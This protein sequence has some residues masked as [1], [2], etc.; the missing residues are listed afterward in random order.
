MSEECQIWE[1][2]SKNQEDEQ[3]NRTLV[4]RKI[5]RVESNHVHNLKLLIIAA[6]AAS[7]ETEE[8]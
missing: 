7:S 8:K 4:V 5:G 6:R 1:K 2:C 3:N